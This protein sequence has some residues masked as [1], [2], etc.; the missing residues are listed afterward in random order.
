MAKQLNLAI[1]STP[2]KYSK[3]K[4]KYQKDMYCDHVM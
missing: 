2:Q 4:G 1:N 3:K